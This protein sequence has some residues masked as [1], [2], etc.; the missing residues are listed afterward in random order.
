[1]KNLDGENMLLYADIG[2]WHELPKKKMPHSRFLIQSDRF[3]FQE[4]V[5][6]SVLPS[7]VTDETV[8]LYGPPENRKVVP[9]LDPE[10]TVI[11]YAVCQKAELHRIR[12]LF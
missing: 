6:S 7:F 8:R 4:L 3:A 1:M 2:F 11:Y 10:A 9:I 12:R 5:Q